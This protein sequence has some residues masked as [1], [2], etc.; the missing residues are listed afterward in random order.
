[1]TAKRMT[2][3]MTIFAFKNVLCLFFQEKMMI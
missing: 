3:Y 2:S 1:M